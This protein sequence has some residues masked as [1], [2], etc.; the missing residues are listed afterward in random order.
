MEYQ[1][2]VS[3]KLCLSQH[4]GS[5][6]FFTPHVH[7]SNRNSQVPTKWPWSPSLLL[8]GPRSAP[9][10]NWTKQGFSIS[11]W[12][13]SWGR[14]HFSLEYLDTKT[15]ESM[16]MSPAKADVQ[17][18]R[19]LEKQRGDIGQLEGGGFLASLL[20]SPGLVNNSVLRSSCI[21]AFSFQE[22]SL[23]L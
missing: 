22:T 10:Q 20:S 21:S 18:Q 8:I 16:A 13:K 9:D 7:I 14:T 2:R 11:I 1:H 23:S 4:W 12:Y 17:K 6:L 5:S 19:K 15:Q 3:D